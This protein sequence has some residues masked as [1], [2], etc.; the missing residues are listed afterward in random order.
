MIAALIAGLV[1]FCPAVYASGSDP[2][3]LPDLVVSERRSSKAIASP[4]PLHTLDSKAIRLSGITD[5]AGALR[6]LPGVNIRDYGGAGGLKTVSV[7]GL[8][9]AHTGVLY[10]GVPLSEIRSGE[11]DLSRYSLDNVRSISL[12]SGDNS[13]IF[14]PARSA[15]AAATVALICSDPIPL[16]GPEQFGFNELNAKVRAGSFRLI[17]PFVKV[18]FAQAEKLTLNAVAEF[19]HGRNDYPFTLVNGKVTERLRRTNSEMNSG[20]G[21]INLGWQP[22]FN[23][24]LTAKVYYYDN[25]RHLPGPVIY[26]VDNT[27]ERLHDRNFFAQASWRSR[28]P[29]RLSLLGVAKYNNSRTHYTDINGIYPGGKLDQDYRQQE[30]YAS[31]SLMWTGIDGL[32]LDYS[33]DWF[34]NTLTSNTSSNSDPVRNSLLQSLSAKYRW[35]GLTAMARMI[36][37]WV[38][39]DSK[40]EN[41]R[42]S[43]RLSPSVSLSWQPMREHA[44]HI[45]ASYRDIFRMPSFNELYFDNYG[46]IN[47]RPETTKQFNIGATWQM[48]P[49][50]VF[51]SLTITADAYHNTI[52]NKIVAVPFN[53]FRYTMT[54][55]GKVRALGLD[56]ALTGTMVPAARHELT[57]SVN[58]SYQRAKSR[59]S[60][61]MLDWNKQIPYTPLNSG[62]AS[63]TWINPLVG[64]TMSATASSGRYTTTNN[65]PSTRIGG[66][67]DAGLSIF[68]DFKIGRNEL[69]VRGDLLNV[70]D[71]QYEIV[72][73]YP[74]PGRRWQI[75]VEIKI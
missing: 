39:D 75:S 15:A 23:N 73:R 70:F 74:M 43:S 28:L 49:G 7:R 66:Y 72:A 1:C 22:N 10:D 37:S 61:N 27:N 8:G 60:R 69:C 44:F 5:V 12:A 68:R 34:R 13:D 35:S 57:L 56:L 71:K 55:L 48:Q 42:H 20:H 21:E 52:D 64:F 63:L 24:T 67:I 58:Y 50:A 33:A 53:L 65:I 14:I 16:D 31:A 11:I 32:A 51:N 3:T 4:T 2:D 18:S 54:N 40:G 47:L 17:N 45:R 36:Y 62:G 30:E 19:Q 6:R 46:S 29:N 25:N 26:Y 59:T 41:A 9:A 38:A